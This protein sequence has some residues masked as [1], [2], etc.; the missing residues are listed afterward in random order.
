M[1]NNFNMM[2]ELSIKCHPIETT[3][4]W[5]TFGGLMN[6]SIMRALINVYEANKYKGLS[7]DALYA[8]LLN[9]WE[10]IL[11]M[12]SSIR[13]SQMEIDCG[14]GGCCGGSKREVCTETATQK[15]EG[16]SSIG[17]SS[18]SDRRS[19]GLDFDKEVCSES[20]IENEGGGGCCVGSK[21]DVCTKTATKKEEGG[22]C[23]GGPSKREVCTKT[24]TK[25]EGGGGCCVG[26]KMDVCT[27]TAT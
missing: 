12:P 10:E 25:K 20:E 11:G 17:G 18:K 13:L 27:K 22:G 21:M 2:E 26:S 1:C 23:C 3:F 5:E 8:F 7:D 24:V 14:R 6:P 15:E 9:K 4:E 16:R 19:M